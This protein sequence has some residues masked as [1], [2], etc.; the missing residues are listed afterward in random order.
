MHL[1]SPRSTFAAGYLPAHSELLSTR[2]ASLN[3]RYGWVFVFAYLQHTG[4]RVP[5]H[6]Q[7]SIAAACC[8]VPIAWLCNCNQMHAMTHALPR[9]ARYTRARVCDE[10][11]HTACRSMVLRFCLRPASQF[12]PYSQLVC[13]HPSKALRSL[14]AVEPLESGR[15]ASRM[16]RS[17]ECHE[18][19]RG[20]GDRPFSS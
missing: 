1:R 2:S 3:T 8:C 9:T 17:F 10:M 4:D 11:I 19:Q 13:C 14:K 6:R 5:R 18:R 16:G 20:H 7:G 12:R 15:H